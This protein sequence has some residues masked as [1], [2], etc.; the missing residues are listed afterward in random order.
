MRRAQRHRHSLNS[1]LRRGVSSLVA[2]KACDEDCHRRSYIAR[3]RRMRWAVGRH[4]LPVQ[5]TSA[6]TMTS[7]CGLV[8][9][10]EAL[11]AVTIPQPLETALTLVLPGHLRLRSH[12]RDG[13]M[14]PPLGVRTLC[15][16]T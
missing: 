8:C 13:V 9:A 5:W 6:V 10:M 3:R 16:R 2:Q 11:L 4:V 14:E 7:T 12:E 15:S 1:Q